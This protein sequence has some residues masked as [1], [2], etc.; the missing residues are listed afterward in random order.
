VKE[1]TLKEPLSSVR[2]TFSWET[3]VSNLLTTPAM[4]LLKLS[5]LLDSRR[6]LQGCD[7]KAQLWLRVVRDGERVGWWGESA[8]DVEAGRGVEYRLYNR[9][10]KSVCDFGSSVN[11]A[12]VVVCLKNMWASNF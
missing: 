4:S 9:H 7:P 1:V 3:K 6:A 8:E 10:L 11:H 12:L 5:E 2:I